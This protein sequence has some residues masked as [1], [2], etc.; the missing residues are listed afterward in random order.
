MPPQLA[1]SWSGNRALRAAGE[2]GTGVRQDNGVVV[3][4]HHA[5]LRIHH[6]GLRRRP[7]GDLVGVVRGR[8]PRAD[9][10]E[11]PDSRLPDQVPDGP[12]EERRLGA[13][14]GQDG[15]VRGDHLLG[16][17]PVGRVVV[18]AAEPE[19]IDPRDVRHAGVECVRPLSGRRGGRPPTV[20]PGPPCGLAP[21]HERVGPPPRRGPT[22]SAE[23]S[24]AHRTRS[25]SG[26]GSASAAVTSAA[27][28]MAAASVA[29]AV[30]RARRS[31]GRASAAAAATATTAPP[32]QTAEDTPVTKAAPLVYPPRAENT[33][34]STATPNTPPNSRMALFA[35]EA[36]PSSSRRTEPSTMLATG[37]K[38]SDMPM[39][40]T[41]NAGTRVA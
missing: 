22:S 41:T 21:K 34:P 31:R 8:P 9:V 1:M 15:R 6:A 13:D 12:A 17:F 26:T 16:G 28:P 29:V 38:N 7:L 23:T 27:A 30:A 2:Q 10:G 35:P 37:A 39:P 3:H 11:L 18:P 33:A 25:S 5:G 24:Q 4:I 32:T 36:M 40:A 14:A 20:H 19:V